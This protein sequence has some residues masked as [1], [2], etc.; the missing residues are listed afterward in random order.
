MTRFPQSRGPIVGQSGL[1]REKS[2]WLQAFFGSPN[3]IR[4][5]SPETW[6]D[7][8]RPRKAL[9]R[10]GLRRTETCGD[11]GKPRNAVGQMWATIAA[12]LA[13]AT[14]APALADPVDYRAAV[15]AE[16]VR[17]DAEVTHPHGMTT[18]RKTLLA[19][20]VAELVVDAAL[21]VSDQRH[22]CTQML[23]PVARFAGTNV[24][25]NALIGAGLSI[26]FAFIPR[27]EGGDV[28]L[29]AIDTGL[30]YDIGVGA[31]QARF[32]PAERASAGVNL[33]SLPPGITLPPGVT[34]P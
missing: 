14:A 6:G 7:L 30:A 9:Q 1:E 11:S 19:L 31:G 27:G 32:C 23:N 28:A 5:S 25:K 2:P 22:G 20:A 24:A 21:N 15:V 4:I 16:Q 33:N 13:F 12:L 8:A 34:L 10:K 18:F 29:T 26:G 3:G 17:L